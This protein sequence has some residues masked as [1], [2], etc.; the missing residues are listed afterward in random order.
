MKLFDIEPNT[1]TPEDWN[2]RLGGSYILGSVP[3]LIHKVETL[4]IRQI[5][6]L[7]NVTRASY[8]TAVIIF[9]TTTNPQLNV[10]ATLDDLDVVAFKP[11]KGVYNLEHWPVLVT[12]LPFRQW[13]FG[14]TSESINI[15][16]LSG[17]PI[18]LN[19][20]VAQSIFQPIYPT[21]GDAIALLKSGKKKH[22]AVSQNVSF[23]MSGVQKDRLLLMYNFIPIATI[24]NGMW[25]PAQAGKPLDRI[26]NEYRETV[27]PLL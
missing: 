14:A 25:F 22:V 24:N 21:I 9:R 7:Q 19:N 15:Q 20:A 4:Y 23:L 12:H 2:K 27:L 16:R 26:A 13:H 8:Q 5:Q 17:E 1:H 6:A 10:N 11:E 3:G 18:A